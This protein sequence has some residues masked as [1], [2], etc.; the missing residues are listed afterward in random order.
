MKNNEKDNKIIIILGLLAFAGLG[1]GLLT[2]Y[3]SI[4]T[5]EMSLK[6]NAVLLP[7][8]S[9]F[10]KEGLNDVNERVSNL[11]TTPDDMRALEDKYL[12]K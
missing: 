8:P 9:E 1:W 12:T 11:Q 7:I 2:W 3:N 4:S 10:N 6:V 5:L